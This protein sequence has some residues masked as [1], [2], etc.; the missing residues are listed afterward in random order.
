MATFAKSIVINTPVEKVYAYLSDPTTALEYWPTMMDVRNV[1]DL[2]DGKKSFDWTLKMAG[3]K[4]DGTSETVELVP[5][6]HV[7]LVSKGG[8]ESSISWI[9]TPVSSGTELMMRTE[10]KVPVPVLGRLAENLIIKQNERE[11]DAIMTNIKALLEV[12]APVEKA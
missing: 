9:F 11:T 12:T 6:E 8:I 10:Y 1:K 2:G 5:N 7:T 4:L 3:L